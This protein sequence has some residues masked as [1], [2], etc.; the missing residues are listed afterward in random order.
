MPGAPWT[1]ML[2]VLGILGG[3]ILGVRAIRQRRQLDAEMSRKL[4]HI[5]MGVTT[6]SFPWIFRSPWPVLVLTVLSMLVMV[7]LKRSARLAAEFGSVLGGVE[8][9]SLGDVTFPL[10]VGTLF[11]V[12]K[13]DPILF[14][15]PMLILTFGDAVAALIGVRYGQNRYAGEDGMKSFEG[16]TAFFAVAFLC[17]H[18]PLLLGTGT[19]RAP[20]LLIGVTIALMAMLLEAI[21]WSG[22]DNLFVPLG[23]YVLLHT[24]LR[25]DTGALV[26]RLAAIVALVIFVI[27]RRRRSTLKDSALLAA[28]LAGYACWAVGG[29]RWLVAPVVLFIAYPRL[30]P[31]TE[32][33]L[34]KSHSVA[35][36]GGVMSVG[37]GWMFLANILHCPRLLW[38][39]T[40]AFT[41]Q[42]A[43]VGIVRNKHH[44]G[45]GPD[46][47]MVASVVIKSWLAVFIP[48][49]FVLGLTRG[50][51]LQTAASIAVVA[52]TSIVFLKTCP[53]PE[54]Q[55]TSVDLLARQA[56]FAAVG[57]VVGWIIAMG[58]AKLLHT[59]IIRI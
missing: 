13:G 17:V 21:A 43:L 19:G 8:R 23:A 45:A 15:V 16:S 1:G 58:F 14:C 39:Y 36:V 50:T 37:M 9:A 55:P 6:L 12:S 30:G 29:L 54:N 5:G 28:A 20:C 25:L 18:V 49:L 31:R 41:I 27:A 52:A 7:A 47:A 11:V 38:P 35:S 22:L 32:Q 33:S 42:L 2:L 24:F 26:E 10:A 46:G 53:I 34:H 3:L 59:C 57:S 40:L 48:Y 51:L 44:R 4:V 56:A